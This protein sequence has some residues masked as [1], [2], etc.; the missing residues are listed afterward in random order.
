MARLTFRPSG[1]TVKVR[2]GLTLIAAARTARVIIPQRCGGHASCL[3]CKVFVEDGQV[4]PPTALERRKLSETD[5]AQGMRLACQAQ[6]TG[7]D[8]AVRIPEAKLKSIVAAALKCQQD[9]EENEWL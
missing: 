6:T 3:M 1:K 8:C 5:L 7:A 4:S 2:A 9:E